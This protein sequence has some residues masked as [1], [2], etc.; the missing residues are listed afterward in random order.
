[1]SVLSIQHQ[2]PWVVTTGLFLERHLS[3]LLKA[4]LVKDCLLGERMS[5]SLHK[6]ERQV[7]VE[8]RMLYKHWHL[9]MTS[10]FTSTI[11]DFCHMHFNKLKMLYWQ[12]FGLT[13]RPTLIVSLGRLQRKL[14]FH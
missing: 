8:G 14:V 7:D 10:H 11:E 9:A 1:M 3:C 6:H 12:S 4:R 5:M 2:G 13:V